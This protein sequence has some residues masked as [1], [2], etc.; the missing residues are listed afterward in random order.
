MRANRFSKLATD[1]SARIGRYET[2]HGA[3]ETPNFMPVGT[4]ASVKGVDHERLAE[5]GAQITLVN[6]YHLWLRPGP[7]RIRD[8]GGIHS[9]CSW[10]G[11][12]LSDSGGFQVFSLK[13]IRKISEEGVE[14]RSHIDGSAKFLSPELSIQIQQQLGVDIA[15]AFDE[16]PSGDLPKEEI[17]KSLALTVRWAKRSLAARTSEEMSLF[18]ITQGG[19]DR[20]LRTRA[21][22]EICALPFDGFAIGGL[23]VGEKKSVMYDVLSYHVDQLPSDRI[24][25]LMGVGTP[26]DICEAV[27]RGIDLFDCVMPTRAGRFGRV[28]L[29][30]GEPYI[31]IKNAS[32]ATQS[33]PLDSACRCL[34]CRRYS[35]AYIHHLFRVGEMLGPQLASIHNLTHYLT[36]MRNIRA[37]IADGKFEQLYVSETSRWSS[38][39]SD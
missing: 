19:C 9:F 8:L 7:E 5:C 22:E 13:G 21:A 30:S 27:C 38:F 25:Y 14:F 11:P 12:I 24:R 33:A 3:F 18:G 1:R 36:L 20:E 31:N 23:S 10:P 37:A 6:T 34:A 4:Q 28:F 35:R 32:Y 26:Q 16:C 2:S 15:M 17:E 29:S 39:E